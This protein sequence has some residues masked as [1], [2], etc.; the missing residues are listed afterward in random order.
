MLF[1]STSRSIE[2]GMR[3]Q[4]FV[5]FQTYR[6]RRVKKSVLT[7]SRFGDDFSSI[8]KTPRVCFSSPAYVPK[9]QKVFFTSP[10]DRLTPSARSIASV[11]NKWSPSFYLQI[12]SNGFQPSGALIKATLINGAALMGGVTG[13]GWPIDLPPSMTQVRPSADVTTA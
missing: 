9:T 3:C 6:S 7:S 11:T 13:D 8:A 10:K 5:S 2:G 4:A 12:A 1:E